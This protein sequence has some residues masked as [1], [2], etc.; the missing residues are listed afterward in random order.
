MYIII[1]L[2]WRK[3]LMCTS[4]V[5]WIDFSTDDLLLALRYEKCCNAVLRTAAKAILHYTNQ[6]VLLWYSCTVSA[7]SR[8][9]KSSFP[10]AGL[11]NV[12][13]CP[14]EKNEYSCHV[15]SNFVKELKSSCIVAMLSLASQYIFLFLT[16]GQK[17]MVTSSGVVVQ[18]GMFIKKKKK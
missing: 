17:K 16:C 9:M 2:E 11:H 1:V 7:G 14:C 4:S 18:Y 3:L 13:W 12:M 8:A 10:S 5:C 6:W 15:K